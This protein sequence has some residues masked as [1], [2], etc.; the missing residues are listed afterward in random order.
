[1]K[2]KLILAIILIFFAYGNSFAWFWEKEYLVKVNN[3]IIDLEDYQKRLEELH[4]QRSMNKSEKKPAKLDFRTALDE[5]IDDF[6]LY[7]EGLRLG[8]DKEPDFVRR[9]NA[10]LEF[11]S[12]IRLR[13]EEVKDKIEVSEEEVKEFYEKNYVKPVKEAKKENKK[14]NKK[15]DKKEDEKKVITPPDYDKVK[16]K[17]RKRLYKKKEKER[18]NQ[19]LKQLKENAVIKIDKEVLASIGKKGKDR[20]KPVALING[21]PVFVSDLEKEYGKAISG[22]NDEK[23]KKIREKALNGLIDYLLIKQDALNHNYPLEDPFFGKMITQYRISLMSAVLKRKIIYPRLKKVTEKD[24]KEYYK[25]N[26]EEY[27]GPGRFK[28]ATIKVKTQKDAENLKKELEAGADFKRLARIKT[29]GMQG[30]RK[31]P[32]WWNENEL[33]GPLKKEIEEMKE[34]DISGIIKA[35]SFYQIVKLLG[36][37]KGTII[38]YSKTKRMIKTHLGRERYK[39]LLNEYLIRLRERSSIEVNEDSLNEFKKNFKNEG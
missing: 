20:K 25:K 28:L 3:E 21:K 19:Y 10:Y 32:S 29:L 4:R 31:N 27:R 33:T 23:A 39:S 35:G 9:S 8:L 6:L 1:M 5:M 2:I 37:K 15:K 14:E 7:Q 26:K 12:I 34:G 38:S 22:K 36:I 17:I 13:K 30:K 11:Q 24:T 16:S 18:E